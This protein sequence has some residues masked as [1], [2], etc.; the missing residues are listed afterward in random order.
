MLG[1]KCL[2]WSA[3]VGVGT[4]MIYM[5]AGISGERSHATSQPDVL[6]A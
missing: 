2:G 3:A 5:V 4:S 6:E 1:V